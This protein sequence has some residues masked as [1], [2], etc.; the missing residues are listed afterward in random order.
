MN[1]EEFKM[2]TK[3]QELPTHEQTERR[4]YQIYLEH[5]FHPDNALAD[6]L[7]AESELTGPSETEHAN[8]PP[9]NVVSSLRK[10]A[11]A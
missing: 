5:G 4:A 7:A 2:Y 8:I 11:T 9:A 1:K 3:N 10:H 6:W